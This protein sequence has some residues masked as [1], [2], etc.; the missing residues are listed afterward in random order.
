MPCPSDRTYAIPP[1]P[2]PFQGSSHSVSP[3][4]TNEAPRE[5]PRHPSALDSCHQGGTEPWA[6][7]MCPHAATPLNAPT[8][9]GGENDATSTSVPWFSSQAKLRLEAPSHDPHPKPIPEAN[10]GAARV[11]RTS[12]RTNRLNRKSSTR[13]ACGR[14]ASGGGHGAPAKRPRLA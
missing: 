3:K 11:E 6:A 1:I 12:A 8:P 2:C 4:N 14:F 7:V 10:A 9:P 5:L 13:C